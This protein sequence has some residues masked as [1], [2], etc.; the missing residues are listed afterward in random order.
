MVAEEA[1]LEL[2]SAINEK[3]PSLEVGLINGKQDVYD[4]LIGLY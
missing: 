4:L 2:V 3:W 1:A